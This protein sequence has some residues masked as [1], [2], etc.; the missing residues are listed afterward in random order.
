MVGG[1]DVEVIV[2]VTNRGQF[3]GGR[4]YFLTVQEV[5][6]APTLEA[7]E[8]PTS[9]ARLLSPPRPERGA[10]VSA[11]SPDAVEFAI[12]LQLEAAAQ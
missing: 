6:P 5:V 1:G 9:T 10:V 7:S 4:W 2:T 3:G 8:T 12:I 11:E